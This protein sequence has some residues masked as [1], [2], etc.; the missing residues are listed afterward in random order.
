MADPEYLASPQITALT[1]ALEPVS[2]HTRAPHSERKCRLRCWNTFHDT[3]GRPHDAPQT[4]RKT[5]LKYIFDQ[6]QV[7]KITLLG[8]TKSCKKEE[9]EEKMM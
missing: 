3:T 5:G 2:P 7:S 6:D 1:L 8:L 9:G 4:S